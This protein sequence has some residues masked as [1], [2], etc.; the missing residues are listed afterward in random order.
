M[1]SFKADNWFRE[2]FG[3]VEEYS[4]VPN[5]FE[6]EEF[7]DHA[8]ITS[9]SNYKTYNA[10][11]FLVLSVS[12]NKLQK[13]EGSIKNE[14][15]EKYGVRPSTKNL[16]FHDFINIINIKIDTSISVEYCLNMQE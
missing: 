13:H 16:Y 4:I 9:K 3:F 7:E 11:Q 2:I 12:I 10:G 1:A 14:V 8:E 6:I 15:R 5:R